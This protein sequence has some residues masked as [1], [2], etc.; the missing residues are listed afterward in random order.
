M[1]LSNGVTQ[2]YRK[3]STSSSGSGAD[4]NAG[5]ERERQDA[6]VHRLRPLRARWTPPHYTSEDL[7]SSPSFS[8]SLTGPENG[9][10]TE[11]GPS[12]GA[13][14]GADAGAVWSNSDAEKVLGELRAM[15]THVRRYAML[16]GH[17]ESKPLATDKQATSIVFFD[18]ERFAL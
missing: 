13:G 4:A 15:L 3:G 9:P 8:G 7:Y 2:V 16:G 17:K 1:A 10:T 12:A 6:V 11:T 14:A 18:H 5:A